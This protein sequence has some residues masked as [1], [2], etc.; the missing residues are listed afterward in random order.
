M[1]PQIYLQWQRLEG[2]T[3]HQVGRLLLQQLYEAHVGGPMPPIRIAPLGKPVFAHG[4]WHFSISHTRQHAFC[5]LSRV[6]VGLDGEELSRKVRPE[7][8]QKLLSPTEYAQ[9]L[10]AEDPNRAMLSFWVLKE[11]TAKLAGTGIRTHPNTTQF[12]LP[13]ARLQQIDGCVVAVVTE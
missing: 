2:R 8:A 1:E 13:D 7:T 6:P 12:T 11:A 3:G 10:A 9:Y 5:V 4:D